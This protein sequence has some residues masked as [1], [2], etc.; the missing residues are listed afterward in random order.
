MHHRKLGTQGLEVSAICVAAMPSASF[1]TGIDD[2]LLTALLHRAVELGANFFD[3]AEVCGPFTNEIQVGK[4]L[5]PFLDKVVIATKFGYRIKP[6]GGRPLGMDSSP[7]RIRTVC[8][9][10]R[11]RLGVDTIDLFYQHRVDPDVPIEDVAGTIG[12]LV[13]QGK[14]R[15]WGLSEAS[16]DTIRRAHAVHPVS[17]VESEYSLWWR[18]PEKDVLPLCRE[19]GIGFAPYSPLGRGFLAGTGLTLSDLPEN[20]FRRALPRWQEDA[21][22]RNRLLFDR[23]KALADSLGHTPGQLA[24][25]W[26]LHQGD[27]IVP[28]PGTTKL[29]RMEENL[30]AADIRLTP[31]DLAA[32]ERALPQEEVVGDRYDDIGKKMVNR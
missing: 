17:V 28:I 1:T 29:H 11:G 27:D 4:A 30:A 18:Q 16:V 32:I 21:L 7:A 13:Q 5:K 20:D 24:L 22:A 14:V 12:E 26:L 2:D 10:S 19:L 31:E 25:A 6:E 23:Y 3:T 15:Y 9:E 8:D